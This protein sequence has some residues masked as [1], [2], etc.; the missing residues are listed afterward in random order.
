MPV[1]FNELKHDA[2]EKDMVLGTASAS[3]LARLHAV[4]C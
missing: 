3:E 4:Q 1:K 2:M